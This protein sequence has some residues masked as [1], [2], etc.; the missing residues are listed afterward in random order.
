MKK[1]IEGK[2]YDTETAR[3]VGEFS[4]PGS[5][6]DFQYYEESL[7]Q[8]RT[9]EYFLAGEG[10][11]ASKYSRKTGQNEWSGGK[12]ITPVTEAE[13]QAWAEKHLDADEYEKEFT[14]IEDVPENVVGKNIARYRE[15]NSMTQTDLAKTTGATQAQISM[16]ESGA[17][18]PTAGRIIAIAAALGIAPGEL[19][20]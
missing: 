10:G 4:S 20:K 11:P 6:R 1:I 17:Q 9:G 18:D 12:D 3:K 16:Y 19:L 14:V 5:R 15:A 13:A 7:Y 8:K 2:R